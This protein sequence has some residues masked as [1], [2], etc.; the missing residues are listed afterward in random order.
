MIKQHGTGNKGEKN[1]NLPLIKIARADGLRSFNTPSAC[2]GSMEPF[3]KSTR[4]IRMA[5]AP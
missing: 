5:S 2:Q 3:G 1:E 4:E